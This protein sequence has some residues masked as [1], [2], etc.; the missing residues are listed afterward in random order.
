MTTRPYWLPAQE[1]AP[2]VGA[3]LPP[4]PKQLFGA[5]PAGPEAGQTPYFQVFAEA[6]PLIQF[7]DGS[8][9]DPRTVVGI[10]FIAGFDLGWGIEQQDRVTVRCAYGPGS[11]ESFHIV[12]FPAT[13]EGTEAAL[14][15]RDE[16]AALVNATRSQAQ[17]GPRR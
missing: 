6:P 9:I 3:S 10:S 17:D 5:R 4:E 16:L 12:Y 13:K 2:S 8:W 15:Y 14:A 7:R 1:S 11:S